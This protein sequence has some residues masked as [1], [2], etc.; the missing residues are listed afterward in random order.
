MNSGKIVDPH[1]VE[2]EEI[3]R[4]QNVIL[5]GSVCYSNGTATVRPVE[6]VLMG[7][8]RYFDVPL[9]RQ[10]GISTIVCHSF[11]SSVSL[12]RHVEIMG[13]RNYGTVRSFDNLTK[14]C[15]Y[16]DNSIS[17]LRQNMIQNVP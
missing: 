15:P 4:R 6:Q 7:T 10:P 1:S 16:F 3:R 12:L 13:C 2:G 14:S 9:F 11:D 5:Y 17:I 8:Y